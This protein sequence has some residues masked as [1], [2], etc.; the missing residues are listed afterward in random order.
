MTLLAR[1]TQVLGCLLKSQIGQ[2][3]LLT[4]GR[5]D[6]EEAKPVS[7]LVPPILS[8]DGPSDTLKITKQ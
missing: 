3:Y 6:Q 8:A 7:S 2:G 4:N 1:D 5:Q